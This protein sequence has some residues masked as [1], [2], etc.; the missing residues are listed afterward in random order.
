[1]SSQLAARAHTRRISDLKTPLAKD[2]AVLRVLYELIV[3]PWILVHWVT[4]RMAGNVSADPIQ[5]FLP[6]CADQ[7]LITWDAGD[8]TELY[9]NLVKDNARLVLYPQDWGQYMVE[10]NLETWQYIRVMTRI[11]NRIRHGSEKHDMR[12]R[13]IAMLLK[14]SST[15]IV[16]QRILVS[17]GSRSIFDDFPFAPMPC[18]VDT[19]Y[20]EAST[21]AN[22]EKAEFWVSLHLQNWLL[23]RSRTLCR[24]IWHTSTHLSVLSRV[25]TMDLIVTTLPQVSSSYFQNSGA[26]YLRRNRTWRCMHTQSCSGVPTSIGKPALR[27]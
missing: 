19:N 11:A 27:A 5:T 9:G 21:V 23:A 6:P 24:T 25:R 17:L 10:I 7:D 14:Y 22:F 3:P 12:I 16:S 2:L 4:Y 8:E 26:A 13:L 20:E 15:P 18:V 1:M